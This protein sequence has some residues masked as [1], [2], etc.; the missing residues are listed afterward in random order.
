MISLEKALTLFPLLEACLS[1]SQADGFD[2]MDSMHARR[3]L[4]ATRSDRNIVS[5]QYRDSRTAK[6]V[7]FDVNITSILPFNYQQS[8]IRLNPTTESTPSVHVCW[9]HDGWRAG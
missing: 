7:L 4:H 9:W 3:D 6:P 1:R 5:V 8:K 2:C